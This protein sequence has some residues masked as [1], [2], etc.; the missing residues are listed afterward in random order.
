M[1]RLRGRLRHAYGRARMRLGRLIYEP[2]GFEDTSASVGLD[3]LRL[4]HPDRNDYTA[5]GW[6]WLRRVLRP[7]DVKPSDVFVDFGSGKGRVVYEAARYPFARVIGVEVSEELN[8]V[9]RA[10]I[11]R[12]KD[13]LAC[14]QVELVTCDAAYF[15][16]PDDMTFAYLYNPF[17]GD[18][19]KRV[20]AHI[21][22]SIDRNPR[23]VKVVYLNPEMEHELLATGRFELVEK[24]YGGHRRLG[25]GRGEIFVYGSR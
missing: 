17:S 22:E 8:R 14:K 18:T 10:N 1:L 13:R 25:R 5:S 4:D 23:R 11:E 19:F 9:A 12:C 6:R 15:E 21:I 24:I 16:I 3:E 2:R 7:S 20:I